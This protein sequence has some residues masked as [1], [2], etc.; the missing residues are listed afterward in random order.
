MLF[1]VNDT[2]ALGWK[3]IDNEWH[4]TDREDNIVKNSIKS[5]N[6]IKMY[7]DENGNIAKDYLLQNY[8][9]YDYYF[10]SNG[11]IVKDAEIIVSSQTKSNLIIDGNYKYKFDKDGKSFYKENIDTKQVYYYKFSWKMDEKNGEMYYVDSAGNRKVNFMTDLRY[12]DEKGMMVKNYFLQD[13]CGD[14]YYFGEDGIKIK[15]KKVLIGI[16][17]YTNMYIDR[18]YVCEFD[19]NGILIKKE[20]FNNNQNYDIDARY[21]M[22]TSGYSDFKPKAIK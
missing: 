17:T 20:V 22:E 3:K 13:F 1:F 12:V 6:N 7:L 15:S 21:I 5:S 8:N 10:D 2:F 4:Y 19:K 16:K 11:H 9:L 18:E 14:S